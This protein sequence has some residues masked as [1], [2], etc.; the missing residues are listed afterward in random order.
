MRRFRTRYWVALVVGLALLIGAAVGCGEEE[1]AAPSGPIDKWTFATDHEFSVRPD[2]LPELQKRYGFEFEEVQVMDLGITYGALKDKK[3][4]AA[5]GFATDGRIAAFNLVNLEDDKQ[6]FPVYNPAPVV[7]KE[8]MDKYPEL[9]EILG[10]I[11]PLLDTD[12]MISLNAEVDIDAKDP[13]EVARQWLLEQGLIEDEAPAATKGKII[14]GSKE[15]TEQLILGAMT[16][17]VLADAGYEAVDKT[18]LAGTD[19]ARKALE[20]GEIDLYWE[21][22]G[23]AW[24]THLGHEEAITDSGECFTKVKEEDLAKH[25]LVWLDYARFDNTY[26][27]MMRKA[28]ADELGIKTISDLARVINEKKK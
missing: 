18:G 2:G 3:V 23:T 24:L 11:G 26:T 21:Y 10:K 1:A 4:A 14:V 16:L 5:M 28:D 7:R 25:D 9:E 6:F 12:T 13:K 20:T 27:I 15:F 22:T 17:Q 8:V 19:V